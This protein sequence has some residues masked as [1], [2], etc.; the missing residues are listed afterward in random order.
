MDIT[1]TNLQFHHEIN[2]SFR[3]DLVKQMARNAVVDLK[4]QQVALKSCVF[5][6]TY[7]LKKKKQLPKSQNVKCTYTH[8]VTAVLT[9]F[10]NFPLS[11]SSLRNC[12]LSTVSQ[13][14]ITYIVSA[15]VICIFTCCSCLNDHKEVTS[16]SS[17]KC[18]KGCRITVKVFSIRLSSICIELEVLYQQV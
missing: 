12:N 8:Q 4:F 2:T 6:A 11:N 17:I 14:H 3:N 7:V 10:Y 16:T 18:T 15:T 5:T 9:A 1:I 13:H